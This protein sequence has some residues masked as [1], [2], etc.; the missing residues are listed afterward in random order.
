MRYSKNKF[1]TTMNSVLFF[2]IFL[3]LL[4]ALGKGCGDSDKYDYSDYVID[5]IP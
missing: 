5:R 4:Y 1:L 2:I 3:V